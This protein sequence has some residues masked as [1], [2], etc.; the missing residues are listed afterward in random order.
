M[1]IQDNGS[2]GSERSFETR[3]LFDHN[4]ELEEKA[5]GSNPY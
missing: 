3:I 1:P 5:L 2:S 4:Y